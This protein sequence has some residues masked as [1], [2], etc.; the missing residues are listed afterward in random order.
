MTW[1]DGGSMRPRSGDGW[2]NLPAEQREAAE[3]AACE[4]FGVDNFFDLDPDIRRQ[5]RAEAL[6]AI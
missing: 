4:Q 6:S 1:G 5:V 2:Q 3:R